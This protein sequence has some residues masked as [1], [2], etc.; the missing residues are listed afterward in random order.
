[1]K[2]YV[3]TGASAGIGR[4]TAQA[5]ARDGHRV[6]MVSRDPARAAAALEQVKAQATG[7]VASLTADLSLVSQTRRVA[8]ELR[9]V[10]QRLDALVLNAA[11]VPA[12]RTVTAEGLELALATNVLSPLVLTHELLP[13][14]KAS[15]PSRVVTFHGGNEHTLDL[16]DLQ[17]E[18]GWPS[19][20][21]AYGRTKLMLA[22]VT[23]ELARRLAGT[24]VTVNSAWPGIVN[25]EGMR[26]MPG[27]M[28]LMT[29]LMRP[30]MRTPAQGALTPLFVATAPEL[31]GVSGRF[32]GSMR[33]DGRAQM[34]VPE[35]AADAAACAKLY[36]T[37]ARL[38][39][40]T[41]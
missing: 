23:V 3:V 31:E 8:K 13:L 40:V 25:T 38:A 37:C 27:A 28:G 30:F 9:G 2:T 19:G 6:L 14:L 20:F 21:K 16:D 11:V 29:L 1:M 15:A 12:K 5:L 7:E 32:Y 39:G 17:A 35:V 34:P 10:L 18:R 24:G 33:G 26:A 4:E 22:M 36:E 41:P